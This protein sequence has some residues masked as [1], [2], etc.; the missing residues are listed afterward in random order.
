MITGIQIKDFRGIQ[1][2]RIDRFRKFNLLVGPNNSGKSALMEALYLAATAGRS[3]ALTVGRTG[4]VYE[5]MASDPDLLGY[6]PLSQVWRK[7]SFADRQPGLGTWRE[8]QIMVRIPDKGSPFTTFDLS[9]GG[10]G[11]ARGEEEVIGLIGIEGSEHNRE[12]GIETVAEA[13]L[14]PDALPL[15]GKRLILLWHAGLTYK[16][17]GRAAWLVEGD[18]P[19]PRRVLFFDVGMIDEH[20]PLAFYRELPETIPGWA[21]RIARHFGAIFDIRDPLAL[22]V[23]PSAESQWVQGHIG[24]RD[25][26]AMR[27]D[28]YGDGA[29][30]AFKVLVPLVTLA[31]L[32]RPDETG[33]FLWEEPELFQHPQSLGRLLKETAAIVKDRPIQVFVSTQSL[34]AVACFAE[35]LRQ[36]QIDE[37]EVI[38][39]RL[40]LE[41]SQLDSSWFDA[42]TLI[43]WLENGWDP[44]IWGAWEMAGPLRFTLWEEAR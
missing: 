31:E 20:L 13:L 8:G 30:T 37:A 28:S 14:G 36:D 15:A 7:H 32:V 1:T 25:G 9:T 17:K 29:R 16:Q 43:S 2:G 21:D 42:G 6:Q 33:L 44:R 23:P 35:M 11:F 19:A 34:E 24:P 27:I 5:V 3:A 18:R 10:T 41:E 38:A 4:P 22:F 26:L 40:A 39:F 12:Q